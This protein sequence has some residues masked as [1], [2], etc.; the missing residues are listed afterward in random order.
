VLGSDV[1]MVLD[2]VPGFPCEKAVAERAVERTL[3]WAQRSLAAR[4]RED[5]A[6]FA[7]IQGSVWPDLRERCAERLVTLPFPGYAIG[8]VSVGEDRNQKREVVQHCCRIVPETKPRYLMGVGEPEDVLPAIAAG[9]DLFDCVIPT[10]CGRN[11]RLYTWGGPVNLANARFR[12][13]TGPL[14]ADCPCP[15]CTRFS[16]AY[17]HHLYSRDEML[18]P[19]LGTIHN[20]SFF[21]RLFSAARQSVAAGTFSAFQR[22]FL[23]GFKR[24]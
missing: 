2:E 5:R 12:A 3:L 16:A 4:T 7:I 24:A 9:V 17:L 1:A 11:K 6:V 18:G 20:L 19:I 21:Q 23:A 14:E 15:A 8:G 13:L 10:R 22:D